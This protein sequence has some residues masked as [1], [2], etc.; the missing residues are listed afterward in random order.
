MRHKQI[1]WGNN[2]EGFVGWLA[3]RLE[4]EDKLR[5]WIGVGVIV[6]TVIVLIIL[7]IK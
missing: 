1:Q 5:H 3:D 4:K 2:P 6:L 7:L